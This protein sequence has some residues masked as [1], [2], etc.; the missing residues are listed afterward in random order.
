MALDGIVRE[1]AGSF[2]ELGKE[3]GNILDLINEFEVFAGLFQSEK[4]FND[5]MLSPVFSRDNKHDIITNALKDKVSEY[6]CNFINTLI[7][8]DRL[9]YVAKICD[10]LYLIDDEMN[11]RM[12]VY[13]TVAAPLCNQLLDEFKKV[14]SNYFKKEII[15][16]ERIDSEILGGVVIKAGDE[17]ID[18]SLLGQLNMLK[19]NLLNSKVG[20]GLA[21]ES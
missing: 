6:T 17:L 5:L 9:E 8:N 12:N 2:Y 1:Y 18:A 13:V 4:A 11:N 7:E 15:I 10:E 21:Y 20:S 16:T 14:L 3:K 19:S